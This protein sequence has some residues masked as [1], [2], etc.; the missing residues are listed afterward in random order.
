MPSIRGAFFFALALRDKLHDFMLSL[1]FFRFFLFFLIFG[2]CRVQA[3]S[4][5]KGHSLISF[6]VTTSTSIASLF[7]TELLKVSG[8]YG[9]DPQSQRWRAYLSSVTS[10]PSLDLLTQ[11]NPFQGYFIN[12]SQAWELS[13]GS[14]STGPYPIRTGF[15]LL[16]IDSSETLESLTNSHLSTRLFAVFGLSGDIWRAYFHEPGEALRQIEDSLLSSGSVQPLRELSSTYAYWVGCRPLLKRF[17]LSSILTFPRPAS[18]AW[19]RFGSSVGAHGKISEDLPFL[20]MKKTGD[21]GG[22]SGEVFLEE[23]QEKII[24]EIEGSPQ[25]MLATGSFFGLS[26]LSPIVLDSEL[27]D[28]GLA[29]V[30]LTPLTS[31]LALDSSQKSSQN[32]MK[33]ASGWIGPLFV[34]DPGTGLAP[35]SLG[36][37]SVLSGDWNDPGFQ[38]NDSSTAET[39][40]ANIMHQVMN[41]ILSQ[42][43]QD[44]F[45]LISTYHSGLQEPGLAFNSKINT[46]KTLIYDSMS[47]NILTITALLNVL[48]ASGGPSLLPFPASVLEPPGISILNQIQ[49]GSVAAKIQSINDN[50]ALIVPLTTSQG[51][52]FQGFPDAFKIG[53][54]PLNPVQNTTSAMTVILENPQDPENH[55]A[56]VTLDTLRIEMQASNRVYVEFPQSEFFE[57]SFE[58]PGNQFPKASGKS[59]NQ[60]LDSGDY[61]LASSS[62]SLEIPIESYIDKVDSSFV[63]IRTAFSEPFRLTLEFSGI[64]FWVHGRSDLGFNK[65]RIEGLSVQ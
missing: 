20:G 36:A 58:I 14:V 22:W 25:S 10:D 50:E 62:D 13:G 55:F 27:E 42:G 6:P 12:L 64:S 45:S 30:N 24:M 23:S 31:I 51:F 65:I 3:V 1:V 9:I 29:R 46:A 15:S 37:Y 32:I 8:L 63:D 11:V 7:G 56:Q 48:N 18:H 28:E 54:S 2:F 59:K 39:S 43:S 40:P 52:Q 44:L 34:D 53:L 61:R 47:D 57:F 17:S 21:T 38:A 33:L 19:V 4:L 35:L 26:L 49:L 16:P 41:T 60:S 5:P